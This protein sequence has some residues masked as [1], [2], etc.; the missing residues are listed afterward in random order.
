MLISM[1]ANLL[2]IVAV[3]G[4]VQAFILCGLLF[5][6]PKSDRTVNVFLGLYIVSFSIPM[7]MPLAETHGAYIPCPDIIRQPRNSRLK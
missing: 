6:H 3:L 2:L 1:P 7:L 4:I 5:F